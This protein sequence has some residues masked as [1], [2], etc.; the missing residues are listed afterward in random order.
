MACSRQ[1]QNRTAKL[2]IGEIKRRLPICEVLACYDVKVRYSG[3]KVVKLCPFHDEKTA[4]HVR[5]ARNT[6]H[7]FAR[8]G[9]DAVDFANRGSTRLALDIGD[10]RFR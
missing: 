3:S 10:H 4:S 2:D 7:C 1:G 8:A 6:F 9:G 5:P